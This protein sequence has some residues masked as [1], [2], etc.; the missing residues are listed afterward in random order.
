MNYPYLYCTLYLVSLSLF[1]S[2]VKPLISRDARDDVGFFRSPFV[3]SEEGREVAR[4]SRFCI[5]VF[6]D[7]LRFFFYFFCI[8]PTWYGYF[9]L[10]SIVNTHFEPHSALFIN[11][12][13][14]F[15]KGTPPSFC[16]FP[17]RSL[18]AIPLCSSADCS[19]P[20]LSPSISRTANS[21]RSQ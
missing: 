13:C 8:L 14:I 12:Y 15:F 4:H 9:T 11:I 3:Q 5:S 20:Y 17:I 2:S 7:G 1:L 10:Y 19:S 6:R 21:S 18:K 16:F